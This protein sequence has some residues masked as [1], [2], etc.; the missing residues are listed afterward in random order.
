[1]KKVLVIVL[2]SIVALG[3]RAQQ[4]TEISLYFLNGLLV[5]PG[6]A[7]SKEVVSVNAW[8]RHQWSGMPGAPRTGTISIHSPLKKKQYALGLLYTN[9]RFGLNSKNSVYGSFA[10]RIPVK[11]SKLSFGIQ[12]GFDNWQSDLLAGQLPDPNTNAGGDNA[13]SLNLNA[14][15]PNAGAGFYAYRENK[16]YVGLSVPHMIPFNLG[17]QIEISR[18]EE[19][20]RLYTHAMLTAG[21]VIGKETSSFKFLPSALIKYVKR[22]PVNFN[23][24]AGFLFLDRVMLGASYEFASLQNGGK[25]ESIIGVAKFAATKNL[26]FGYAYD[27]SLN[28]LDAFNNGSHEVFIG[29]NF[30]FD[31]KRFVTP[32]FVSYF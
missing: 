21:Y 18:S 12:A 1:M 31:T 32:R 15:L 10:Y 6:Y 25:S 9:D 7:G 30:G 27:Y 28:R 24:T 3:L 20:S 16:Y 22:A 17:N 11:K 23:V 2:L 29:Y 4:N 13:F 19:V 8:Y 5:N 14:F 26:E